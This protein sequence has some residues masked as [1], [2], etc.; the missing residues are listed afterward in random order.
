MICYKVVR[1]VN[2]GKTWNSANIHLLGGRANL[3]LKYTPG[4]IVKAPKNTMGIFVFKEKKHA[5]DFHRTFTSQNTKVIKVRNIG[6]LKKR[7]N[8][9][10]PTLI[11]K[12]RHYLKI[13]RSSKRRLSSYGPLWTPEG[14]YTCKAVLV[15]E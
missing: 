15:L 7:N 13:S 9:V 10:Y 8:I 5:E 12:F 1:S 3:E 14:T 4:R 2:S 6:K 11:G